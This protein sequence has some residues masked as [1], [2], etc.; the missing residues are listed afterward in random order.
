MPCS[1]GGQSL[2]HSNVAASIVRRD[3]TES[4]TLSWGE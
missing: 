1:G 4:I 2:P 3:L